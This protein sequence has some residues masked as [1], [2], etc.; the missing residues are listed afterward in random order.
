MK[1]IGL[2]HRELVLKNPKKYLI[3]WDKK[4][5]S[6]LQLKTKIF[7]KPYWQHDI[8]FEEFRLVGTRLTFDFYNANKKIMIEV[9]GEQHTKFIKFFHT[10][11]LK[12]LQQLKRDSKKLEFCEKNNI[13]LIEI[14]HTDIISKDFFENQ[15]IYL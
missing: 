6:K 13:K 10:N 9:Q 11:R 3:D 8:V 5:R 14:Y 12:Y 7:L 15:N 1:F 2:N 4:S